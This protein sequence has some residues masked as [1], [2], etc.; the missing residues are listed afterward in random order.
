MYQLYIYIY[1]LIRSRL[2]ARKQNVAKQRMTS[3]CDIESNNRRLLHVTHA[4]TDPDHRCLALLTREV[5]MG[6]TSPSLE[7]GFSKR[8]ALESS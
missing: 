3:W 2:D 8:F 1:I 4:G 5:A 6:R 7:K